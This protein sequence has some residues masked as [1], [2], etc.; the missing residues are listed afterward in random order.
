[1]KK[2]TLLIIL[3]VVIGCSDK[4]ET[5]NEYV[6]HYI[7]F[8]KR[9][10]NIPKNYLSVSFD[11]YKNIIAENYTDSIF[12]AN[13]VSSIN[14][15]VDNFED[16]VMFVDKNNIEN[17]VSIV[18]MLNSKP[19]RFT[20]KTLGRGLHANMKEQGKEQGYV[21]KPMENKLINNWL[22]KIKGEKEYKDLGFS[23]YQTSYM[24]SS[25][26]AFVFNRNKDLDFEKVFTK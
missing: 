26:A 22:I 19:N 23:I 6:K 7:E 3:S 11:E 5:N 18:P 4:K 17:I 9:D 10:I 2:V 16:Y 21:Y 20:A 25:F 8:L 12:V 15:F 24:A 13:K 14:R 1:M